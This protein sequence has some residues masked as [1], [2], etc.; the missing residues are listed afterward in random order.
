MV[1]V[2]SSSLRNRIC[3]DGRYLYNIQT[4]TVADSAVALTQIANEIWFM[5]G[6]PP[7][8]AD[9]SPTMLLGV[10]T[11]DFSTAADGNSDCIYVARAG[12]LITQ[13]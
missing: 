7:P 9:G 6:L 12:S 8:E 10:N 2:V 1:V 5:M 11:S 3:K 13:V 4:G